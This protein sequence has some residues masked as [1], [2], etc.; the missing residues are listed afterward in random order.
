MG[1]HVDENLQGYPGRRVLKRWP[2]KIARAR[3]RIDC[4]ALTSCREL[5][6]NDRNSPS[7]RSQPS[8]TNDFTASVGQSLRGVSLFGAV[9][10]GHRTALSAHVRASSPSP[11]KVLF[12]RKE[13]HS[14]PSNPEP[15]IP[16][17]HM[18]L[19]SHFRP[20]SALSGRERE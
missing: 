20:S 13:S 11:E 19:Q 17:R 5:N 15:L 12:S 10:S 14:C 9:H 8:G 4:T 7:M 18:A 1:E 3:N 2:A 16:V 6:M